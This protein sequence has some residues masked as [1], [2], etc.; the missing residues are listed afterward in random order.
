V[1]DSIPSQ[2][3]WRLIRP[4]R[5]NESTLLIYNVGSCI[6]HPYL[7]YYRH[8]HNWRSLLHLPSE[9]LLLPSSL[10]NRIL[11]IRSASNDISMIGLMLISWKSSWNILRQKSWNDVLTS[12]ISMKY[13][14]VLF[15]PLPFT[16]AFI[17][18]LWPLSIALV[19]IPATL[20]GMEFLWS[21]AWYPGS[22]QVHPSLDLFR[23]YI[24]SIT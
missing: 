16:L 20:Q 8:W 12:P 21:W 1:Q 9:G 22:A 6:D 18:A 23:F 14:S 11:S 24:F 13:P 5:N 3:Q 4:G 19:K 17:I 15:L 10:H 7:Q 2:G